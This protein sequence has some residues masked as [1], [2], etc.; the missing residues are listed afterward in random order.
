MRCSAHLH[1]GSPAGLSAGGRPWIPLSSEHASSPQHFFP[2][3]KHTTIR[4]LVPAYPDRCVIFSMPKLQ[5]SRPEVPVRRTDS[6]SRM[7]ELEKKYK[8]CDSRL[9][10]YPGTI[11]GFIFTGILDAAPYHRLPTTNTSCALLLQMQRIQD[12][13]ATVLTPA[14]LP[15]TRPPPSARSNSLVAARQPTDHPPHSHQN[16]HLMMQAVRMNSV[17]PSLSISIPPSPTLG[18][19]VGA[20]GMGQGHHQSDDAAE[21]R[22]GSQERTKTVTF[23]DP[24]E[25]DAEL[26]D[27]SSI[28]HSP[29][30]EGYGQNKKKAK[31]REA[32]QKKKEKERKEKEIKASGKKRLVKTPPLPHN[33]PVVKP[34]AVSNRSVSAPVLEQHQ[35]VSERR[36]N[37]STTEYP[38]DAMSNHHNFM[39]QA[40]AEENGKPK[41]KG[42]LSSFRLQHSNVA[43]V[44][45][46][47]TSS[48]SSVDDAQSVRSTSSHMHKPH[49]TGSEMDVEFLNPRKPPSI[50]SMVS[51]ST[52]SNSSHERRPGLGRN[53]V[54]NHGRTSSFLARLK[55]PS[56]L[57]HHGDPDSGENSNDQHPGPSPKLEPSMQ[58]P[59]TLQD[60]NRTPPVFTPPQTTN[61]PEA[62]PHRGRQ[63]EAH[64][65]QLRDSSSDY[66]SDTPA[67]RGRLLKE[68]VLDVPVANEGR[69]RPHSY[70]EKA[71]QQFQGTAVTATSRQVN[72]H[73][74]GPKGQIQETQRRYPHVA[75]SSEPIQPQVAVFGQPDS[76]S[77]PSSE[78][79]YASTYTEEV[80]R[81]SVTHS[82]HKEEDDR[83]SVVTHTST[84][85]PMSLGREQSLMEGGKPISSP[86][87][88][89]I[90]RAVTH[91]NMQDFL[92]GR[93]EHYGADKTPKQQDVQTVP[94]VESALMPEK[95]ADY[96]TFI[97]EAY[98]P[99]SLELRSPTESGFPSPTRINE[100]PGEDENA[101]PAW[102]PP[103]PPRVS[104]S[105]EQQSNK[106]EGTAGPRGLIAISKSPNGLK[107]QGS[108]AISAHQSDKDV[109]ALEGAEKLTKDAKE[110]GTL[111]TATAPA[112]D[113]SSRSTSERSSSST[114]EDV[115]PSPSTATTPDTSRPQS[116]GGCSTDMPRFAFNGIILGGDER[117][118]R[119]LQGNKLTE[120][121]IQTTSRPTSRDARLQDDSWSR[122]ALP[123]ELDHDLTTTTFTRSEGLASSPSLIG[124]PT[125]ASF[126]ETLKEQTEEEEELDMPQRPSLPP[127]AQSAIDLTST[128]FLPPLKHQ[129][130]HPKKNRAGISSISLPSSPPPELEVETPL[131]RPSAMKQPNS[132]SSG[133]HDSVNLSAGAAYLQEARKAAPVPPP[134]SSRALRPTYPHK[135]SHPQVRGPLPTERKGEPIAKMLV[136]CCS[137]KF[138]HDMPSR[139]YECMAKPDSV[140]EDRLLGVSAAITTMVKCPW[141]A[142]GMTTQCCSGYA[143]VVFLKEKLHGHGK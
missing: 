92:E 106:V 107:S 115:P 33:N 100:E 140:V 82:P 133:S 125:S 67:L 5:N 127:K 45:K 59:K 126:A 21:P 53:S 61:K 28:C 49:P 141:C 97:S 91:D 74:V 80:D 19:A 134:S 9:Q 69:R 120:L 1:T 8:V 60:T 10:R 110:T 41:G 102:M 68:A 101:G 73:P 17:L 98:A 118:A 79:D 122:T 48:R 62:G 12:N 42:F 7:L 13:G 23:S 31:K 72:G 55:G 63:F 57:Y 108:P 89:Q 109:P 99:P 11:L 20:D 95:P 58:G 6:L 25:D 37:R 103:P 81:L 54:S 86:T 2:C 131:F 39:K 123:L 40:S 87:Q 16:P 51:T 44:Q 105:K 24:E 50:K 76:L 116:R 112:E 47:M 104:R 113:Q 3:P 34:L 143:A 132:H 85:R 56:Y 29:S 111:T 22:K 77:S 137:C 35:K 94:S 124:T 78:A 30:W 90:G 15:S 64:V 121:P 14:S 36:L 135:N 4:I 70:V 128:S 139:V 66:E 83:A 52:Q 75:R 96:F 46:I 71:R 129:S 130:L 117:P 38:P 138:F 114:C 43:A 84:I 65:S 32:A 136:E 119:K 88:S 26:S 27:Q 93:K 18:L 142:H